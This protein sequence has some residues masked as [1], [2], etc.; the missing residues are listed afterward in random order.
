MDM[1]THSVFTYRYKYTYYDLQI[2][3][4]YKYPLMTLQITAGVFLT[5]HCGDTYVP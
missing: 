4:G 2:H 3:I 5:V 1:Q